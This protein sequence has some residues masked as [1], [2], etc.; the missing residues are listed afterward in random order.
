MEYGD[1]VVFVDRKCHWSCHAPQAFAEGALFF[2]RDNLSEDENDKK[3]STQSSDES[4][5]PYP[6]KK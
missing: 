5:D 6:E 1:L 3:Q 2:P 4:F